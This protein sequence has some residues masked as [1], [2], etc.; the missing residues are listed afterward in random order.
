MRDKI[1]KNPVGN[2]DAEN[3]D[4]KE[5]L[6]ENFIKTLDYENIL[7]PSCLFISGRKGDGKTAIALKLTDEKDKKGD[8]LYKYSIILRK[9]DFYRSLIFDYREYSLISVVDPTSPIKEKID[10]EKY[11]EKLWEYVIYVSAMKAVVE[12]NSDETLKRIRD[13]L[14]GKGFLA[15]IDNFVDLFS[16]IFLEDVDKVKRGVDNKYPTAT[17]L[18]QQAIDRLRE[19]SFISALE[20]LRSHLDRENK[21][22]VIIDTLEKYYA[23]EEEFRKAVQGMM[24]AVYEIKLN[25]KNKWIDIKC[26]IPDELYEDFAEWNFNKA[27]DATVF[28]SWKYTELLHFI[29][30]R[31][32]AYIE[33]NYDSLTAIKYKAKWEQVDTHNRDSL[34]RFWNEFF[35][36]DVE[37][38][39]RANED[40]FNYILRHSQNKPRQIIH[41]VNQIINIAESRGNNPEVTK[42]DVYDGLHKDL[43]QLVVD[44][45]KPFLDQY[46]ELIECV[47]TMFRGKSNI[48]DGRIVKKCIKRGR[49]DYLNMG[50]NDEDIE[51]ILLRSGLLGIVSKKRKRRL[52]NGREIEVYY[53]SFD[54]LLNKHLDKI[55]DETKCALHS[56][57]TDYYGDSINPEQ[58]ICVYPYAGPDQEGEPDELFDPKKSE[59]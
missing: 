9:Y 6:H 3:P 18:N 31:Y 20:S 23:K 25:D 53:T 26:F 37:D 45:F 49:T 7:E 1:T 32:M 13:F 57:L 4:E 39:F 51:K 52:S 10:I 47:K 17:A 15:E 22:L 40:C 8:L 16:G 42:R 14:F 24:E 54:Y 30:R 46:Q 59:Y 12:K 56:I 55:T 36:I 50:L 2:L 58:D 21:V 35:P 29:S 11:F 44:N 34:R 41:L 33:K 28:L 27:F 48:L 5:H 38:R 19:E 43:N